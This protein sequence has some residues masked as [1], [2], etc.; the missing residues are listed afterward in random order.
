[1]LARAL[2]A[3]PLAFLTTP[4]IL[5]QKDFFRPLSFL[6][7]GFGAGAFNLEPVAL[8]YLALPFAV[9][10]APFLVDSF[11]P[12]PTE[13]LTPLFLRAIKTPAKI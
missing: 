12:L 8:L 9:R 2:F 10:P 11:S 1:M 4:P 3:G 7:R 5:A 6:V 13:S